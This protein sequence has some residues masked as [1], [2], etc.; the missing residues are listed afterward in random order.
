MPS[1]LRLKRRSF[2]QTLGTAGLAAP[3]IS[4]RLGAAPATGRLRHASF[5]SGGMAGLDIDMICS[6]GKVDLVAVA[7]VDLSRGVPEVVKKYPGVRVYQDWRELLDRED[8]HLDSVNVSTPDHMHAAMAMA[9]MQRGKH[10]YCQKPLAHDIHDVRQLTNYARRHD[11]VTQMGIQIHSESVYKE[12]VSL[13]QRGAVGRIREVHLWSDKKWGDE[14]APPVG[15]FIPSTDFDW[16]MWLGVSAQRPFI[17][18]EYYHPGNWRK[19]LDF[20]TGTFG[21]MGCHIFDPVFKALAL[22]APISVRSEGAAPDAWNWAN[23]AC[24]RYLFPSTPYTVE[25]G[26]EFV[27]YDGDRRPPPEIMALVTEKNPPKNERPPPPIPD[28]GS[29]IVGTEGTM[30][31]PHYKPATLFPRAKFKDYDRPRIESGHHWT[32]WVDACLGQGTPSTTFDYAGPLTEAVLLGSVAVRYPHQ[33]LEWDAAN[34][35]FT[36]E[37]TAN[38]FLRRAPRAGWEVKGL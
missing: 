33:T 17:G 4:R 37:P 22:N 26:I 34:L 27:W 10:V 21:D 38:T 29:V 7:D 8:E 20:G 6:S 19:R 35:E 23:D 31:L 30:L 11:L 3:L 36:N 15:E 12:A 25:G 16:D 28:Q 14:G 24:I 32:Q 18:A 13:V 1:N 9:A 5:G 2:L